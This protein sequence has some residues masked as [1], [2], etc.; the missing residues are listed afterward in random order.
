MIEQ[1]KTDLWANNQSFLWI[2]WCGAYC[3]TPLGPGFRNTDS[4]LLLQPSFKS[5][6]PVNIKW[7]ILKYLFLMKNDDDDDDDDNNDDNNNNNNN[8]N[9]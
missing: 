5:M 7:G 2:S 9:Y 1:I 4:Y 6:S 8:N 3:T